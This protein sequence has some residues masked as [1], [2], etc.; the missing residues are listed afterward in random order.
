MPQKKTDTKYGKTRLCKI[1][2]SHIGDYEEPYLQIKF[3][4]E[5]RC[6]TLSNDLFS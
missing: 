2:G 4:P 5:S 1:L 3:C 6:Y